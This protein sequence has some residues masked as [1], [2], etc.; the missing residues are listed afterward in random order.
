MPAHMIK[1][2]RNQHLH[3]NIMCY[4]HF[5]K[6]LLLIFLPDP[7][8]KMVY[9]SKIEHFLFHKFFLHFKILKCPHCIPVTY[10]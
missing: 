9:V 10:T 6:L 1:I 2:C 3:N 5:K 8:F 4:I 7:C